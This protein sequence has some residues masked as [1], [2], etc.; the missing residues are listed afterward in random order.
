MEKTIERNAVPAARPAAELDRRPARNNADFRSLQ[1]IAIAAQRSLS[2]VLWDTLCGGS[3]SEATLRRNRMALDSLTLRQR[4]LVDVADM[5]T[6]TT[7][8][9]EKLRIPVFI[10]PVGN[11]LQL[12]DP[13]GASAVARGAVAYGTTAFISTAARPGIEEVAKAVDKPLLFQ[14]Y[15]RS[16]RQWIEDILLRAKA[17]GYRAICVTVDRAY[18]SRRERD[19]VNRFMLRESQ[20]DPRFQA[21][22]TWDDVVWMKELTKL[23]LILKGIATGEDAKLAVE[24]GADVVYVSNHGGRQLDHG[25]ASIEVLPEV[26]EA[27]DGR[28]EVI[29]DGGVFRGTDVVKAIALGAKAVGVG[30]LQ[31][32]ALAAAGEA[33]I[34]RMLELLEAEI[35][36]TMGLMGVTSLAQ[37]NPS[38][39]RAA[40]AITDGS[41]SGPY[42]RFSENFQK[43]E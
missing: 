20:G 8:L 23:P 40:P 26:V 25:Q 31:G 4:V 1:E 6:T 33:G 5:D 24:H 19:V 32:L 21:S 11:F 2:R 39:V 12:A 7:L 42:P 34:V 17:C 43:D 13:E 3:D 16:D 35:R 36:T 15:V 14:L 41:L 29:W 28:A 27:V 10:A 30:K 18:Y 37:L 9:G 22:L 38:W